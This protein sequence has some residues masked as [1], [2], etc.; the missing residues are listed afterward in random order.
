MTGI[1]EFRECGVWLCDFELGLELLQLRQKSQHQLCVV[2]CHRTRKPRCEWIAYAQPL[3][4]AKRPKEV[5]P[6][7]VVDFVLPIRREALLF[8][9]ED[10]FLCSR[11]NWLQRRA[12]L[13]CRIYL[14]VERLAANVEAEHCLARMFVGTNNK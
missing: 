10:E 5:V 13:R 12:D 1:D 7:Y 11:K 4:V 8:K 9:V 14:P 6:R 2:R 3:H